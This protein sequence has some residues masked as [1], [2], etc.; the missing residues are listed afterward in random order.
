MSIENV[1]SK[2][3]FSCNYNSN[4]VHAFVVVS[5]YIY[6]YIYLLDVILKLGACL[7]LRRSAL[8]ANP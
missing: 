6:I 8:H 2:Y 4:L 3:S 1:H 7:S 5:F